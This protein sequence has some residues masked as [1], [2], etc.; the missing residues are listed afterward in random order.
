M[1]W[2]KPCLV[3]GLDTDYG[4]SDRLEHI[5][6]RI[7]TMIHVVLPDDYWNEVAKIPLESARAFET[8]ITNQKIPPQSHAKVQFVI[9]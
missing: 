3:S 5:V 1:T 6:G 7:K 8:I 2:N 9:L 4:E